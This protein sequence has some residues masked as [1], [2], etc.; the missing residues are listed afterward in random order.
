MPVLLGVGALC[1]DVAAWNA[2][3][4]DMQNAADLAAD[5]AILSLQASYHD[6]QLGCKTTVPLARNQA[7][8]AT[9]YH[10]FSDGGDDAQVTVNIP[11]CGAISG[12]EYPSPAWDYKAVEVVVAKPAPMFL[13]RIVM[14]T[15]PT[16]KARAVAIVD[17]NRGDCLLAYSPDKVRA[18]DVSG[19]TDLRIP[20]GIAVNSSASDSGYG[21]HFPENN[22][23]YVRGN[24]TIKASYILING[25]FGIRDR[26]AD[27]QN[28]AAN[29]GQ[30]TSD[31]YR[32]RLIPTL[33]PNETW[34]PTEGDGEQTVSSI[35]LGSL[36]SYYGQG[37]QTWSGGGII[38]GN[39]APTSGDVLIFD[40]GSNGAVFFID[41]GSIT[42]QA[43]TKLVSRNATIVLTSSDPNGN[44]IGTFDQE[45]GSTVTMSAPDRTTSLETRGLALIQDKL[46]PIAALYGDD[47]VCHVNCNHFLGGA[48]LAVNGAIYVPNGNIWFQGK[49][50]ADDRTSG[51]TQII[52]DSIKWDGA[53]ELFTDKCADA[54]VNAFGPVVHLVE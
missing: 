19:T 20:C 3:K 16:I 12:G 4:R 9:A 23:F 45:P 5:G 25:G 31:P 17:P 34:S 37:S 54:G 30:T 40:G 39:I 50:Q 48:S 7:R 49:G 26:G 15:P 43:D 18:F 46:A 27:I 42:L 28:P 2:Q 29:T 13:A 14:S 44:G 22:A 47:G 21:N 33:V 11:P 8:S 10:G 53:P 1:M 36:P 35:S 52:A 6:F 51:C 38:K 41:Q 24:V 32:N